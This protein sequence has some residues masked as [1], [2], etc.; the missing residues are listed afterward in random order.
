M[1]EE[2]L[3]TQ[4]DETFVLRCIRRG[5]RLEATRDTDSWIFA[6]RGP[7]LGSQSETLSLNF[8]EMEDV[9]NRSASLTITEA[10]KTSLTEVEVVVRVE[11][12]ARLR[13]LYTDEEHAVHDS[14]LDIS[15]RFGSIS[16][17]FALAIAWRLRR[18]G[19]QSHHFLPQPFR[20]RVENAD[21]VLE[22]FARS[23]RLVTVRL[24]SEEPIHASRAI[25][26]IDAYLFSLSY[27]LGSAYVR[28]RDLESLGRKARGAGFR[29]GV[30]QDVDP[31]RRI[32]NAEL[33]AHYQ[34]ALSSESPILAYLSFYHVLEHW[35]SDVHLEEVADR[36]QRRITSPGFSY[37]SQADMLSLIEMISRD[38]SARK[39]EITFDERVALRLVIDKYVSIPDLIASL[40]D[41]DEALR[42]YLK[43]GPQAFSGGKAVDFEAS[44][45]TAIKQLTGRVY[46]TR[47]S[48]VHRKS[49]RENVFRSFQDDGSLRRELPLV[50]L[51]AEQ[52][53]IGSSDLAT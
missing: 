23:T 30:L 11:G 47:N 3:S 18:D 46:D 39:D 43:S 36:L 32:V 52:V 1:P 20:S 10:A 22:L 41:F 48:L 25:S 51:L 29:R 26:L 4:L 9:V 40:D 17:D 5:A 13:P 7:G 44:R 15:Y 50:R 38:V 35:F 45:A 33:L 19:V 14:E 6:S 12:D 16:P 27:N 31:P 21:D 24:R 49:R 37:R 34:Q 42:P 8:A 53:I 2:G 28:I